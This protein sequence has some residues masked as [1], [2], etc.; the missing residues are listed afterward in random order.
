MMLGVKLISS[1]KTSVII[2]TFNDAEFLERSIPSVIK[3]TLKPK[4]IIIIDDGSYNDNAEKIVKR[5]LCLP[6]HNKLA[7]KQLNY[8][9]TK[10]NSFYN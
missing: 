10:V 2:T 5:I 8:I 1:S 4:E 7:K 6:L 9:I 3:Q